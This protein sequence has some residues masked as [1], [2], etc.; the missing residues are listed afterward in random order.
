MG[1]SNAISVPVYATWAAIALVALGARPIVAADAGATE[2]VS[3]QVLSIV[4][5]DAD[6]AGSFAGDPPAAP[7]YRGDKVVGYLFSTLTT[8]GTVGYSGKPLDIIAGIDREAVVT[9]AHLLRHNEPILV[10]G[11][12]DAALADYVGGFAG[13][14]LG[15]PVAVASARLPLIGFPDA[16]AGATV[17]SAV[18]RD[19]IVRA[20][21]VVALSRGMLGGGGGARLD[22]ETVAEAGWG[23]LIAD[24]SIAHRRIS[25]GEVVDAF[26][27][28]G[29]PLAPDDPGAL[30]IDLYAAL[31]TPPRIGENL[32]GKAAFNRLA[33]G[34][35]VDDHAIIVAAD[36][37]YSFKGTDYRRSGRFDRIQIAQG[38][39]TIPLT[40]AGYENVT[41]FHAV[42]AP[43]LREIG[44]FVVPGEASFEPLQ[45]WRLDLL[46]SRDSVEGR[47][48]V[49]MFSL[50]YALP[51]RYRIDASPAFADPATGP[52]AV[53]LWQEIWRARWGT[54][55]LVT[56]LLVALTALLVVQD[57]LARTPRLHRRVRLGFL[58]VTLLWLGWTIGGQLSVV[59]VLT[60]S[61]SLM[62]EFQW[63]FFLLDPAIFLL[64]SFVAVALL[65]WGR[66]VFCGWLCP[67]GALQELSSEVARKLKLPQVTIPFALHERL[68]PIKYVIFVGLFAVSLHAINLAFQGAEVEPFKTAISLRFMRHWPF[69]L[70]A[71]ALVGAGLFVERFF[72]RY[73]CP[74]GA[75]LA[76]PARLRMFEWLKRR[77]QCGRECGICAQRCPVQAIHPSGAINP[78][79]CIYCL[80]CQTLYFD[81]TVCPPLAAI[82]KR[83]ERREAL[84]A[85]HAVSMREV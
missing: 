8:V 56:L 46:V 1:L 11:V 44:L 28:S 30:F 78:N 68:W 63:A 2:P 3:R 71:V 53:P 19:G 27:Q 60:F 23:E 33:A 43:A 34:I 39:K 73:L 52:G 31:A 55:V 41:T 67:F 6:R 20:G 15:S 66:G 16:I 58:A 26:M 65:F 51:A 4:F 24:G 21:R 54:V 50:D 37:L 82:R 9:G 62:G 22:R 77:P 40:A 42:G 48:A 76:I 10:I 49:T 64:W 57:H 18:I 81:D 45:P 69:V 14:D 70:Y 83:R 12:S 7:V 35:G 72:C 80:G 61:H 17:S 38:D 75:A 84:A 85:G 79:E 32:L 36:G 5:P 29:I 25:R 74:L 59:N 47:R 13:I